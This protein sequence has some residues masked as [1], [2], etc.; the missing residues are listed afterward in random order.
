MAP[1]GNVA[2]H[3]FPDHSPTKTMES[4]HRGNRFGGLLVGSNSLEVL[5]GNTV[6]V[7]V[8]PRARTKRQKCRLLSFRCPRLLPRSCH[9]HRDRWMPKPYAAS[10][11]PRRARRDRP[12]PPCRCANTRAGSPLRRHASITARPSA[13][14]QILRECWEPTHF[15]SVACRPRH[16]H[17]SGRCAPPYA[18]VYRSAARRSYINMNR[19]TRFHR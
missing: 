1:A 13:S 14:L 9:E 16:G 19:V 8:P 4:P 7:R 12:P 17:A 5:V 6:G 10:R 2:S 3:L 18:H 11:P 15:E